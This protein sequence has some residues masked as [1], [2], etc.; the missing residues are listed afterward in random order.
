MRRL[1]LLAVLC[2][3]PAGAQAY[4]ASIVFNGC[5]AQQ[6]T[7]LRAALVRTDEK[8]TDLMKMFATPGELDPYIKA[9]FGTNTAKD[10]RAR[11]Q[12]I[13]NMLDKPRTVVLACEERN[14][15]H[16]LY[17]Y[18]QGNSI[19]VCPDFFASRL[20]EGYDSQAGTLIHEFSHGYAD[21]DDNAYGTGSVR[22]LAHE[23]PEKAISNADSYQYF[24]EAVTGDDVPYRTAAWS[25]ENSCQWAFD[26][27]CDQPNNG[28]GSCRAGTD[29]ADCAN[30]SARPARQQQS[31]A[32]IVQHGR[33][34]DFGNANPKDTCESALNGSCDAT[35]TQG[36]DYTD[37]LTGTGSV[38][39]R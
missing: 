38:K 13:R 1:L 2:L 35:C 15:D 7:A 17:G 5:N 23:H 21:T 25:P 27:E 14:C 3:A 30:V 22:L 12:R 37:C 29:A 9:W 4:E 34:P 39:T 10:V 36:T 8:L 31:A 18:S 33:K 26:N 11:Y 16:D 32:D 24:F 28:T 20:S 6:E 19:S